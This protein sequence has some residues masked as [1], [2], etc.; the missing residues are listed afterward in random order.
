MSGCTIGASGGGTGIFQSPRSIF[1]S[2]VHRRNIRGV[3]LV[4]TIGK[5]TVTPEADK[6]A[7]SG[8]RSGS[9]LIGQ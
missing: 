4:S 1:V 3:A 8:R 2:G 9:P 5:A 6:R 7:I